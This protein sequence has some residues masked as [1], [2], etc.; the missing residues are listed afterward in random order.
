MYEEILKLGIAE[1]TIW[2]TCIS[3][4]PNKVAS[5]KTEWDYIVWFVSKKKPSGLSGRQN[6]ELGKN[7]I[8]LA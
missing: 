6:C 2:E 7:V 1:E 3:V 8:R 5:L 4:K